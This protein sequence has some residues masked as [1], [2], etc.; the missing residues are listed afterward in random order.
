MRF[1]F[2]EIFQSDTVVTF[3]QQTTE[4]FMKKMLS[5]MVVILATIFSFGLSSTSHAYTA[6]NRGPHIHIFDGLSGKDLIRLEDGSEWRAASAAEAYTVHTWQ[7]TIFNSYGEIERF[8]DRIVITPNNGLFTSAAYF[9]FYLNNQEDGSYIRVEPVSSPI[10]FGEASF[11]VF[12][13]NPNL[14]HV[15]LVSGR[16]GELSTWEVSSSYSYLLRDWEANDHIVIG[17][18]DSLFSFLSSY[19]Y[20]LINFNKAH[21]VQARPH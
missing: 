7:S 10:H 2:I 6:P 18:Y 12:N 5:K 14:G 19:N 11:W 13:A 3:K 15:Y 20:I 21:F 16:G 9:P 4:E 1:R 8:G 17:I